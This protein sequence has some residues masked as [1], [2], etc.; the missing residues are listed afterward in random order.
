MTCS[1]HRRLAYAFLGL[2]VG[3]GILFLYLLLNAIAVRSTLLAAHA[4]HPYTE[5]PT[6]LQGFTLCLVF[7]SS[8]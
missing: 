3:D 4:V 5:I 2:F 6:V 8:S 1:L 7:S